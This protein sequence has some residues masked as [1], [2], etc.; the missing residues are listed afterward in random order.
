MIAGVPGQPGFHSSVLVGAVVIED[1]MDVER[2]GDTVVHVLQES[3]EFLMAMPTLA[4][5]EDLAV[6]DV[7]RREKSRR[8]MAGVVVRD[9]FDVPEAQGQIRLRAFERLNLALL[10]HAEHE[11]MIRRIEV[12]ADDVAD[13]LDEEGIGRELE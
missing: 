10:V 5:R 1:E 2:G 9:A 12:E 3:E 7:E 11:G 4:L 8:A 13:F 6:G